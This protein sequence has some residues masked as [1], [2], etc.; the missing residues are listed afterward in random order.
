MLLVSP[1]STVVAELIRVRPWVGRVHLRSLC[2]AGCAPVHCVF[3]SDNW[4]ADWGS[5][6]PSGV[7]RSIGIRPGCYGIHPGSLGSLGCAMGVIKFI[8]GL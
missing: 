1:G 2:S 3:F 8:R 6:G 7:A 4:G 5:S